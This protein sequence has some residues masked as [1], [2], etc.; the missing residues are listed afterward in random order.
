MSRA[1]KQ[2]ASFKDYLTFLASQCEYQPDNIQL[3][4]Q[5]QSVLQKLKLPLELDLKLKQLHQAVDE[6]ISCTSLR[7][8]WESLLLEYQTR[9][10]KFPLPKELEI[11]HRTEGGYHGCPDNS[12][13]WV[14]GEID[15]RDHHGILTLCT[16]CGACSCDK[17]EHGKHEEH[18]EECWRESHVDDCLSL[19]HAVECDGFTYDGD[20]CH[21]LHECPH[22]FL[23]EEEEVPDSCHGLKFAFITCDG[24]GDMLCESCAEKHNVRV[25]DCDC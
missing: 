6:A 7:E 2:R 4:T 18:C 16:D 9:G 25:A 22:D 5:Y 15:P 13:T 11:I 12:S 19:Q 10:L 1:A 23:L 3:W 17:C 8:T 24:S 20:T 21:E 14:V